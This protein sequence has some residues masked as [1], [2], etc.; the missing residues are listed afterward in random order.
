MAG[1]AQTTNFMLGTATVMLGTP[2]DLMDMD[3]TNHSIGLTKNVSITTEPQFAELSQ[4]KRN[5]MV[6][7]T[8]TGNQSR[9]S[10]EVYEYTAQNLGYAL[11]MDGS[12]YNATA[13]S[14]VTDAPAS[15]DDTNVSVADETGFQVGDWVLIQGSEADDHVF[16]RKV[17]VVAVGQL[18]FSDGL[19]A[20][21]ASGAT[22][23]RVH[24]LQLGSRDTQ[25][26][27]ACKIVGTTAEDEP[28]GLLFPKVRI[29][30]GF[31]L[32][33]ATDDFGNLPFEMTCYDLVPSDAHYADFKDHQ[34]LLLAD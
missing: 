6:Y 30:N 10:F 21:V 31:N 9:V 8:M 7:S 12:N 32:T 28:I 3:P 18:D 22:V 4:G 13:V 33:F 11:G 1:E 17:T 20:A 29:T 26:F 23:R 24:G 15:A 5:S 16:A 25:P 34:G 14:T 19:P 27:L 2:A